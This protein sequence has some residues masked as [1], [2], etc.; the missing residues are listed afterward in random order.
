ML[1]QYEIH[2]F[3]N[4]EVQLCII[5][6]KNFRMLY[7]CMLLLFVKKKVSI[8]TISVAVNEM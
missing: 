1:K 2:F 7:N 6:K 3:L 4:R 5:V 8:V